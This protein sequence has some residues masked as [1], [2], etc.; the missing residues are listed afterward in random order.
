MK[1]SL[2]GILMIV[3]AILV[4]ALAS[5]TPRIAASVAAVLLILFG[6]LQFR[7]QPKS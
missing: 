1:R 2:E 4:I 5:I 3:A 6:M 7:K